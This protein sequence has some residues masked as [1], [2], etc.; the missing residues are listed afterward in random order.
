M[1]HDWDPRQLPRVVHHEY[2]I[3]RPRTLCELFFVL[4]SLVWLLVLPRMP[5]LLLGPAAAVVEPSAVWQRAYLPIV[6]LTVATAVLHIVNVVRPYWTKTR[7]LAR[8]AIHVGRLVDI[9]NAS[10]QVGFVVAA[11]ITAIEILRELRRMHSRRRAA[12]AVDSTV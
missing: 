4:V 3:P 9:I 7:S 12:Y 10:C 8:V 2:R 6:L 1:N 5:F 11:I